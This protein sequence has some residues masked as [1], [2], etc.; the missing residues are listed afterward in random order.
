MAEYDSVC[1]L[2]RSTLL[3]HNS[4]SILH[5]QLNLSHSLVVV[6]CSTGPDEIEVE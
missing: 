2:S 4:F 3:T 6:F 5:Y 1:Q